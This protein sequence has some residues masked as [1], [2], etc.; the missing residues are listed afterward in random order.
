MAEAFQKKSNKSQYLY[1]QLSHIEKD[2]TLL[3]PS[4]FHSPHS[5][6]QA[7]Q[8]VKGMTALLEDQ[9]SKFSHVDLVEPTKDQ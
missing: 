1:Q 6:T 7:M 4:S 2:L 8:Q 9:I 5:Y 3:G